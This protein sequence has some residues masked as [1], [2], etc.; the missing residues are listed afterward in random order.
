MYCQQTKTYSFERKQ[1]RVMDQ[2]EKVEKLRQR[3]NVT[4][5]DAK[6]ALEACQW[7][8]LDAMVYLEKLGKVKEPGQTVY[9]TSYDAQTQYV[10]VVDKVNEQKESGESCLK[11]LARLFKKAWQ[12]GNDNDFCVFHKDEEIIRVPV[13]VFVLA[14]LFAW[15]VIL[16]VMVVS[17]FFDCRYSFVGKD[18][19]SKVN[20]FM[21][22]ANNLAEKAKEEYDKL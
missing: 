3:A 20:Q 9:S 14:L 18:D 16:I 7:D 4:Y 6:N 19:L 21:S 15:H 22:K 12:K 11:K 13:W 17:L 5:E 10:S 2:L 8:M 1:V